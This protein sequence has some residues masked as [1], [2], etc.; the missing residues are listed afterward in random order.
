M[1]LG[2]GQGKFKVEQ[3]QQEILD[4]LAAGWTVRQVFLKFR[5]NGFT[6]PKTTFYCTVKKI[7]AR[8]AP[9][10]VLPVQ[11]AEAALETSVPKIL[12]L[13]PAAPPAALEAAG[14]L[15]VGAPHGAPKLPKSQ[16]KA[17]AKTTQRTHKPA[18]G[19]LGSALA[20]VHPSSLTEPPVAGA[21]DAPQEAGRAHSSLEGRQAYVKQHFSDSDLF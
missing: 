5:E 9:P 19:S 8:L 16:A 6:V 13:P 7:Q 2:W 18:S 11:A 15:V 1:R 14:R 21:V 3:R 10:Q 4:L 20:S 12:T 17:Q